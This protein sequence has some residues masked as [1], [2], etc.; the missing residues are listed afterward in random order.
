MVWKV[1][2]LRRCET[3]NGMKAK[4]DAKKHLFDIVLRKGDPLLVGGRLPQDGHESDV[5]GPFQDEQRRG[6]TKNEKPAGQHA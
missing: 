3:A 6:K 1:Q 4:D 2:A 5:F